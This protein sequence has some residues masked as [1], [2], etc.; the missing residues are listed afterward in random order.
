MSSFKD[1]SKTEKR[2]CPRCHK[3]NEAKRATW[4]PECLEAHRDEY[5][6]G[7]IA[8]KAWNT[9]PHVCAR[10]YI[11]L[12]M[13]Q[14]ACDAY[15]ESFITDRRTI[16]TQSAG[17]HR[18]TD[19]LNR[20]LRQYGFKPYQSVWEANHIVARHEGGGS[21]GLDN[22]EIVC[23]PCHKDIT[24]EQRRRWAKARRASDIT[25]VSKTGGN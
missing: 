8:R 4:H 3:I 13:L 25:D 5:W 14:K 19:E 20:I 16:V 12:D 2:P 17:Y 18:G 1:V 21:L 24:A 6:Q 7:H 22:I 11:N 15:R 23:V 10:C 9:K